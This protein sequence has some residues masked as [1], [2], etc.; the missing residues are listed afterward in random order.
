[1]FEPT[2]IHLIGYKNFHVYTVVLIDTCNKRVTA[3]ALQTFCETYSS[4]MAKL[5]NPLAHLANVGILAT[6]EVNESI[7]AKREAT[8]STALLLSSLWHKLQDVV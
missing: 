4:N 1:M 7:T 3:D 8:P 5:N 2:W 6:W